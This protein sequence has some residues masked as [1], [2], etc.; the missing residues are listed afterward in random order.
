MLAANYVHES[1]A[2][3]HTLSGKNILE[4]SRKEFYS[5]EFEMQHQ[6]RKH[7]HLYWLP[8]APISIASAAC[9]DMCADV[10][11]EKH[12]HTHTHTQHE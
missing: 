3:A 6:Q 9:T 5:F 8:D 2:S 7:T 11:R 10:A 12:S 1:S 4:T